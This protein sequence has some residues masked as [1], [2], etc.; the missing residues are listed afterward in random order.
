V[1]LPAINRSV[2]G[3]SWVSGVAGLPT[4]GAGWFFEGGCLEELCD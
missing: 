3:I 2:G 4:Y 1:Q